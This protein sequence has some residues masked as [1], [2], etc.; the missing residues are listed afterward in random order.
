MKERLD[1]LRAE[2]KEL[3]EF[4]KLDSE[5]RAVDY[6]LLNQELSATAAKIEQVRSAKEDGAAL[7]Y[8]RLFGQH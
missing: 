1:K 3:E 4:R 5:R 8:L 6:L 7:V 2:N